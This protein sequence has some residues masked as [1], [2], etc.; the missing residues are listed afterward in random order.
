M[1]HG[2]VTPLSSDV[3][4]SDYYRVTK[5]EATATAALPPPPTRMLIRRVVSV[6]GAPHLNETQLAQWVKNGRRQGRPFFARKG[7]SGVNS[8][9]DVDMCGPLFAGRQYVSAAIRGDVERGA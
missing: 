9:G 1:P 2:D 7:V 3:I 5:T 8:D 6:T 4:N